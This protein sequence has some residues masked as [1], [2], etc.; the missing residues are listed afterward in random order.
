MTQFF[1]YS[2][3]RRNLNSILR[4]ISNTSGPEVVFVEKRNGEDSFV[5]LSAKLYQEL[6]DIKA[7]AA[8]LNTSAQVEELEKKVPIFANH[9]TPYVR[10]IDIPNPWRSEFYADSLGT[11]CPIIPGE[12]PCNYAWDW[13]TW[14]DFRSKSNRRTRFGGPV[15]FISDEEAS[16]PVKPIN[17]GSSEGEGV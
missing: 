12:G 15:Y 13:N 14:L 1:F 3:F 7:D 2:R 16:K 9:H 6:M 11:A 5:L 4:Q 8:Y 10:L 17:D